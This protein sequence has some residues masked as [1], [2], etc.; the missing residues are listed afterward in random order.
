MLTLPSA[1]KQI[2]MSLSVAFTRPTFQRIVPLC[3]GAILASGRRTVTAILWTMRGVIRGHPST[4]HRVFS[5]AAWSLWPLGKL[6]ARAILQYIP[7]DQPVLVPMDDTT[8]QHCGKKVYGKGCHH[9]AVRSATSTS[10]GDGD[11]VGSCW[12]SR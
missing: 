3:V 4:Y 2:I 9:D 10:S 7:P 5:R 1:A 11:I 6:L 8:A 12:P